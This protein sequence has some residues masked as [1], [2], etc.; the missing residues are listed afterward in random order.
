MP[1]TPS[2]R[3]TCP[4]PRCWARLGR[5]GAG[6]PDWACAAAPSTSAALRSGSTV[7]RALYLGRDGLL[8]FGRNR[9]ISVTRPTALNDG[10]WH[11]VVFSNSTSGASSQRVVD[12]IARNKLFSGLRIDL[13]TVGQR[14]RDT[15]KAQENARSLAEA[16]YDRLK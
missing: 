3:I 10:Q 2:S 1:S 12:H 8:R 9:S 5:S 15:E 6:G 14:N 7:E 11:H 13:V 4:A 16:V